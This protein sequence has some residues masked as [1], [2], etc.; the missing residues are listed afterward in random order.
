M[1]FRRVLARESLYLVGCATASSLLVWLAKTSGAFVGP[2][3][4]EGPY[5]D[6][7]GAMF[8]AFLVTPFMFY[9]VIVLIRLTKRAI[10]HK[11]PADVQHS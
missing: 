8:T 9:G 1:S 7:T 10:F 5:S 6:D 11:R 2:I 4:S 3:L